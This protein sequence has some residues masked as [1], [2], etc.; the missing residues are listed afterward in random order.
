MTL[1]STRLLLLLPWLVLVSA[2]SLVPPSDFPR[3]DHVEVDR[4]MGPWYVIAH[5]PP[6]KVKNAYNALERYKQVAPGEI[7]TIFTYREGSFSG[8]RRT[9]RPTGYVVQGT[10]NAVWGMQ[11]F[12]PLKLQYVISYVGPEYKTAIVAR[13]KLDYVWILARTPQISDSAYKK[14]VQRV[15]AI[16]YDTAK[17]RRVPQ[18]P[19]DKRNDLHV[20]WQRNSTERK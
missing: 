6:D 2:C 4:F 14:L 5:I 10:G 15:A 13:S 1:R 12:W 3:E 8:E 9:I 16:G 11:F 17:L 18:Q 19:L 7:A 20:D